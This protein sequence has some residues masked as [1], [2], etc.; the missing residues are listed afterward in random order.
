MRRA[1]I[2]GSARIGRY[3]RIGG[4]VGIA[5]HVTIADH[6]EIS[7]YTAITKSIDTAGTYSGVYPFEAN[8]DWR[9][10]A[11]QVRRLSDL[12]RRVAALEDT[13]AALTRSRS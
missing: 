2:A 7:G 4:G 9:R 6:V 11:A 12:A 13:I 5:G 8:R 3:C 10:N 1:G